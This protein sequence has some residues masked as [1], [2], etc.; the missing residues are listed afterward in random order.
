MGLERGDRAGKGA[1]SA[2]L[3][4]RSLDKGGLKVGRDLLSPA[5]SVLAWP[6]PGLGPSSSSSDNCPAPACPH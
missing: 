4:L 6:Q 5:A 3:R 1:I 2:Q